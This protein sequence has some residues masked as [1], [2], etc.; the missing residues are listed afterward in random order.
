MS[1]ARAA[2]LSGTAQIGIPALWLVCLLS[3]FR[4]HGDSLDVTGALRLI[5]KHDLYIVGPAVVE[6][7]DRRR[8][9]GRA[10]QRRL[11]DT[12]APARGVRHGDLVAAD[13]ILP[14]NPVLGPRRGNARVDD[15]CVAAPSK[16]GDALDA[17]A[18]HPAGRPG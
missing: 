6:K 15:E 4:S 11:H 9:D 2:R 18:I 7:R 1:D 5:S 8:I 10:V 13:E 3:T 12:S 14:A 17:R 16:T